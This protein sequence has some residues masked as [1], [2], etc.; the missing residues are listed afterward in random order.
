MPERG[1]VERLE[2]HAFFQRAVAEEHRRDR[3]IAALTAGVAAAD[4]ER[5]AA[6]DDAR[7]R[8]ETEV[9]IAEM[10]SA[11]A[12]AVEAGGAA[13]N[14]RQRATRIGAACQHVAVVAVGGGD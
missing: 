9:G 6:A 10:E 14:L 7:G 8:N 2:A 1:D 12:T 5:D 4:A 11:A 13:E 3:A